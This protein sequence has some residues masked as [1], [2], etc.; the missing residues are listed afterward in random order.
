MMFFS[1]LISFN[2]FYSFFMYFILFY[3]KIKIIFLNAWC[4]QKYDKKKKKTTKRISKYLSIWHDT[5]IDR[6][7]NVD[8]IS[9]R[10]S[11]R[12]LYHLLFLCFFTFRVSILYLCY[13]DESTT[14]PFSNRLSSHWRVH[15]ILAHYIHSLRIQ[16]PI[17]KHFKGR[18]NW[19][20]LFHIFFF[21]LFILILCTGSNRLFISIHINY[22]NKQNIFFFFFILLLIFFMR[23][24]WASTNVVVVDFLEMGITYTSVVFDIP[25][26]VD[27]LVLHILFFFCFIFR[28]LNVINRCVFAAFDWHMCADVR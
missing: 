27:S 19:F 12:F 17:V 14:L 22:R 2:L 3:N 23:F 28:F 5:K 16:A 26:I 18:S 7:I 13:S 11:L 20:Q 4:I 9:L 25:L 1:S 8:S 10:N 21:T 24:E 15:T 6:V